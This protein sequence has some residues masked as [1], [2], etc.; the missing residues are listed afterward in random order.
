MYLLCSDVVRSPKAVYSCSYLA[1]IMASPP[2]PEPADDLLEHKCLVALNPETVSD[3]ICR[4]HTPEAVQIL[5]QVVTASTPDAQN[6]T[7]TSV[8]GVQ[9]Q[10]ACDEDGDLSWS[11]SRDCAEKWSTHDLLLYLYQQTFS[12]PPRV[13]SSTPLFQVRLPTDGLEEGEAVK[14]PR[15]YRLPLMLLQKYLW[16]M[17][18]SQLPI[19]LSSTSAQPQQLSSVPYRAKFLHITRLIQYLLIRAKLKE[20]RGGMERGWRC[21]AFDR[22][23]CRVVKD[24]FDDDLKGL[25]PPKNSDWYQYDRDLFKLG[26]MRYTLNHG[27]SYIF[28]RLEE[29]GSERPRGSHR[30]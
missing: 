6:F 17:V 16:R 14:L 18:H 23:L 29:V 3:L 8:T 21:I 4:M 19:C 30:H 10:W 22:F 26:K 2:D 24:V 12:L 15:W 13:T 5:R 25:S 20:Y 9:N 27:C 7:G 28:C 11:Y 1:P